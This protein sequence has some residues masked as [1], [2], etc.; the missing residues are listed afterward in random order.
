MRVATAEDMQF[1]T[2]KKELNWRCI[3]AVSDLYSL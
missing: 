3:H 1:C 2:N